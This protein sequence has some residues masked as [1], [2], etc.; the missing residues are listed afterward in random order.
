MVRRG[1]GD[2]KGASRTQAFVNSEAAHHEPPRRGSCHIVPASSTRRT[3]RLRITNGKVVVLV[4]FGLVR[5]G[6]LTC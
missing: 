4:G 2:K 5:A 6:G 3:A 1:C